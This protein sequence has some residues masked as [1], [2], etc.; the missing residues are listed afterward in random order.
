MSKKWTGPSPTQRHAQRDIADR[1]AGVGFVLPGSLTVRSYRC[2]KPN[3]A[4]HADTPRLH[5]PYNQWSRQV[6]GRT[7]H[8]NLTP[9]QL[10]D[11]RPWFDNAV[12]LK[13]LVEELQTL[14]VSAVE[15]DPRLTKR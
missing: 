8:V 1:L 6:D 14:T 3:C 15:D 13:H 11:Y 5:G 9:A 12:Q 2:G 4:C 7:T 10:D